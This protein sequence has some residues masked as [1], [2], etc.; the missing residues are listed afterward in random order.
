M[1]VFCIGDSLSLPRKGCD[2]NDTWYAKIKKAFP[3]YEFLCD[4][5]GGRLAE[6]TFHTW[7]AY[8]QFSYPDIVIIQEG[9]CDSSPRYINEN[10][11]YWK[12]LIS[13]FERIKWSGI[14]WRI[15]KL[16]KRRVD[17]TYTK[18]SVFYNIYDE[19]LKSMIDL[20]VKK[21]VIVKIGHGAPSVV[22]KSNSFNNNVDRYNQIFDN[23]RDKYEDNIITIDPLN[24]VMDDM[25]V[26]GYHCNSRGMKAVYEELNKFFENHN[27]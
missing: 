27:E 6:D 3:S 15:I 13:F 14:F 11:Y 10:I 20:G 21:I 17:C 2:Y 16:R 26:D 12:F 7:R 25:F 24:I 22:M 5:K 1:R 8:Y 18:P 23:L 9:V 19:M 4:F